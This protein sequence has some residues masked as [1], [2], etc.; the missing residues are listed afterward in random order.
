MWGQIH[1]QGRDSIEAGLNVNKEGSHR[2]KDRV[3]F[4][5]TDMVIQQAIVKI[6]DQDMTGLH[7]QMHKVARTLVIDRDLKAMLVH[8]TLLDALGVNVLLAQKMS[9]LARE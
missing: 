2:K 7:Q 5:A 6:E 8:N 1:N 3:I 4:L 9:I